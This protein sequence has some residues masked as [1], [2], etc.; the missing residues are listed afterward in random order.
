MDPDSIARAK[1]LGANNWRIFSNVLFPA[2]LA[3]LLTGFQIALGFSW[4]CVVASEM[5]A[6]RSGLGYALQLSRQLLRLD[7][8]VAYM[9]VIGAVGATM[10]FIARALDF[11]CH[12]SNDPVMWPQAP[13]IT[14]AP[15]LLMCS[16]HYA[17]EWL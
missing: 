9:L 7:E 8:V 6:A 2:V 17:E 11:L 12:G 10:A 5:I 4:M 1:L 16:K 13:I 15:P 14:P 3:P